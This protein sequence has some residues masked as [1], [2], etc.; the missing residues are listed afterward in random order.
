MSRTASLSVVVICRDESDRIEACLQSVHGWADEI[1]VFDSGSTDG[2]VGIAR[3]YTDKVW[4]TGWP[5]YGPQRN[6]ALTKASGDWVMTLDADERVTPE[7][8]EAIDR[9]LA[10][11][12]FDANVVK[13]PWRMV[14][15]GEPLRHGR[16]T[17]PQAR[18]FRREGARYR[19]DQVHEALVVPNRKVAVLDAPL[20]HHS[21]RDYQHLQRKHVEYAWL[22]ARQ[23]YQQGKRS[24]LAYASFRFVTDFLVQYFFR[25]CVLDG[26][27]GFL[28]SVVLA[29]YAF[30]KY[31]ALW[32]LEVE[33]K[34]R[35]SAAEPRAMRLPPRSARRAAAQFSRA[36]AAPPL[37]E[38]PPPVSEHHAA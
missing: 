15:F 12:A 35:L 28:M 11:P 32:S 18:L 30:H 26:A 19:N 38:A 22:L 34:L 21:W 27:R 16:Y 14:C 24:N 29:Q 9:A 7:L 23:K 13:V 17:S 37:R 25:L 4:V 36:H 8:R 20:E 31:A 5:G 1:I 6:R 3:R 33:E 2:T 10:D